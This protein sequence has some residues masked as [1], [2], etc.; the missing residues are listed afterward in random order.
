[1]IIPQ[2]SFRMIPPPPPIQGHLVSLVAV[3]RLSSLIWDTSSAFL[4]DISILKRG[5]PVFAEC[6][7]VWAD[8]PS[9]HVGTSFH[10]P[11]R[12]PTEVMMFPSQHIV[13]QSSQ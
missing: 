6:P 3:S 9:P 11:G 8:L 2:I 13:F 4:L 7:S 12:S 10:C 5:R 1:M